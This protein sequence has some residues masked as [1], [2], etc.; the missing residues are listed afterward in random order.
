MLDAQQNINTYQSCDLYVIDEVTESNETI[1][2]HKAIV[3]KPGVTAIL[4]VPNHMDRDSWGQGS[5]EDQR[6]PAEDRKALG[7][8]WDYEDMEGQF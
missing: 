3:A 4:G 6:R 7:H 2:G 5:K 1:Q 8:C